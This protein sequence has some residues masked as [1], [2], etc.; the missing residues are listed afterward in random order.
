L[1]P[2]HILH[3]PLFHS[4]VYFVSPLN[5]LNS[6]TIILSTSLS[7]RIHNC[8]LL[9]ESYCLVFLCFLCF[10]VEIYAAEAKSSNLL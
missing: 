9:E 5:S 6:P 1:S 4:V 10:C 8:W 3:C 7:L 2:F